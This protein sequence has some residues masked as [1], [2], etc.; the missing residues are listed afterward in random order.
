MNLAL[1]A[2]TAED[3]QPVARLHRAAFPGFYLSTL[4][5]PFLV[6]FYRGFLTD[7]TAITFVGK[8]QDGS[9][10]GAV[11]GTTQPAG[12]FGRLL[13]RQWLGFAMA[14]A[15]AVMANPRAAPRLIRAVRYRGGAP[16]GADGALLSSICVAPSE[17]RAGIGRQLVEAWL[18][19][20]ARRGVH[21]AYLTTDAEKNDAVN[22]FYQAQGWVLSEKSRTPEGRAMNRYTIAL[23]RP[24]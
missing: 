4:G 2:L 5:E 12:F 8:G 15:K 10:R 19:E 9:L 14:S 17:Q 3:V 21:A 11:V 20:V 7:D 6:Q 24:R 1:G 18:D 23:D 22:T 16:G 13:K